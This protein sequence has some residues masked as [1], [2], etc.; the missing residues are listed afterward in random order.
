MAD[1]EMRKELENQE[2]GDD[3]VRRKTRIY[4]Y[5]YRVYYIY[6]V[7][8]PYIKNGRRGINIYI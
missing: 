7:V 8:V 5:V 6:I 4:D 3:E 1:W 2:V